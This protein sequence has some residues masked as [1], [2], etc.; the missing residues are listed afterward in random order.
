[1]AVMPDVVVDGLTVRRGGTIV[2][3]DVIE[4]RSGDQVAVDGDVIATSGDFTDDY[5][6]ATADQATDFPTR[7]RAIAREVALTRPALIG[8]QEV[9][10]WR[11]R[12]LTE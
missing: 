7:S 2:L 1:M 9:A 3:D 12:S 11:T 8:L 4:M 6:G 5:A 10:L